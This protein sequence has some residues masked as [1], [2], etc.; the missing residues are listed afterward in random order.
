MKTL[1]ILIA[2]VAV[3][4]SSCNG[5]LSDNGGGK[6]GYDD[7]HSI[8]HEMIVLGKQLEDPYSLAN[9]T[10][11]FA[12]L[13]PTKADVVQLEATDY[14]VRLLP[15]DEEDLRHLEALG[16]KML[17]HPLDYQIVE[18]GDYYHDPEIPEGNITWQYAVV[19]PDFEAPSGVKCELMHK[20]YLA[21]AENVTKAGLDWVDWDAVEEQSYRL[22]ENSELLCPQTKGKTEAKIPSGRITIVDKDFDTEPIGV[23]GVQVSCN[24]FV[25]FDRCYADDEGYYK[26]KKSFK[27]KPRYRLVFTNRKGFTQGINAIFVKGSIST[28]GK[29]SPEGYSIC[30]T[31]NSEKKLFK[32]CVINNA[33]YDYYESCSANGV[34]IKTPPSNLTIW[35]FSPMQSSATLMLHQGAIL[36]IDMIQEIIGVY[37]PI[38]KL[39]LP[40]VILG[41]KNHNDYAS[42]YHLVQ[43]EL[44]HA[45]HYMQ[46]GNKYWDKYAMMILR[47]YL[48]SGGVTYGTGTEED[49][50]YC[51]IGEMW[52][53]YIENILY[54]ERYE[55]WSTTFG[56]RYWF[57]PEIFL[58]MDKRGLNRFKIF[59]ALTSD[60]TQRDELR[61]RLLVLYPECKSVI[62]EAFN[63]Y[64]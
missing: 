45:S 5:T 51:E 20:C 14:Y 42:L 21:E 24:V 50:G 10:K 4:V 47:S 18:E 43:H 37:T 56:D 63:K 38:V 49:S 62:N 35:A 55:D 19:P 52:A 64:L 28:L 36:D 40:D 53:Y 8:S 30:V 41:T 17:D 48:S 46:V 7:G 12:S 32:R 3:A 25:K 33:A 44:A 23:S 60:V 31:E 9:M 54:R 13:Y 27:S 57:H 1:R 61:A 2:G 16:V 6:Y 58:Y 29:H 39:F 22:T 26:M 34:K 15:R 59:A 11:A